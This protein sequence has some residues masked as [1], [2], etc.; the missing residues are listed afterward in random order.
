MRPA[1]IAELISPGIYRDKCAGAPGKGDSDDRK[2]D[3]RGGMTREN[4]VCSFEWAVPLD[5]GDKDDLQTKPGDSFRFNLVYLDA[6]QVPITRARMGGIYGVHLDRADAWGTLRLAADVKDDG[7]SAFQAPAWI[8][9]LFDRPLPGPAARLR[10][11][12]ANLIPGTSQPAP[13]ALFSFR[14]RDERGA[15]REAKAKIYVPPSVR[16]GAGTKV[17]LFFAAGY[18]LPDAGSGAY[19]KRGWAVASP[20]DLP[21]NPLI[22]TANPDI[23]LFTWPA[24]CR[25]SMTSAS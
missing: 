6:F 8:N 4:G 3:G 20:R 7:G 15:E 14:Y 24:P 18:E 17:P 21:T 25:S 10:F 11:E 12:G 22:R 5:S 23:A 1:T 2:Q 9:A 19:L 16:T 13:S